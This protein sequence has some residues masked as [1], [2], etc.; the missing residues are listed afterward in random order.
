MHVGFCKRC[1][2]IAEKEVSVLKLLVG[3]QER[4]NVAN[5]LLKSVRRKASRMNTLLSAIN[6]RCSGQAHS[7]EPRT[8]PGNE[9]MEYG[10]AFRMLLTPSII[11]PLSRANA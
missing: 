1:R 8:G 5:I 7:K 6:L 11:R 4:A 3:L 2:P 9:N 10:Y